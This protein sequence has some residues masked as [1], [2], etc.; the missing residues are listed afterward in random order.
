MVLLHTLEQVTLILDE[1]N[2]AWSLS[3]LPYSTARAIPMGRARRTI[4]TI[5]IVPQ[6]NALMNDPDISVKEP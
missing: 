3:S 2:H 4:L 1:N 5:K 6:S